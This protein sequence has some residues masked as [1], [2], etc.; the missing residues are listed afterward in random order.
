[1]EAYRQFKKVV[2]S[3]AEEKTL[4][5][6]FEEA[7]SYA[8]YPIVKVALEGVEGVLIKGTQH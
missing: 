3:K 2:P 6:E 1:M 4:F 5:K 7:S 8:S